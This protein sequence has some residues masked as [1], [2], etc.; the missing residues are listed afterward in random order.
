N[1]RFTQ[2]NLY[3]T[4]QYID[5]EKPENSPLL[6]FPARRHGTAAT[7][8]FDEHT[9]R[10]FEE[11]LSWVKLT[12]GQAEPLANARIVQP[13]TLAAATQDEALHQVPPVPSVAEAS[14][15]M[16]VSIPAP[17]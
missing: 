8:V 12:V 13:S 5:R 6:T 2:R 4:L 3:A 11:L 15:P 14:A 9:K 7:A 10:Q 16:P 17:A 1:R